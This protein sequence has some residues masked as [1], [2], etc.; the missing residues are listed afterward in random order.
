LTFKP[1]FCL[2]LVMKFALRFPFFTF[3]ALFHHSLQNKTPPA[4]IAYLL[5]RKKVAPRVQI[6]NTTWRAV[7]QLSFLRDRD[8]IAQMI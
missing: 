3:R 7:K 5:S 4:L 2:P 1:V 8:I 6:D